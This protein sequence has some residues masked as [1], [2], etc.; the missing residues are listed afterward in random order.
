[1]IISIFLL[2]S[3]F[4]FSDLA[5][6]TFENKYSSLEII[7]K[8]KI[9][10]NDDSFIFGIKINLEDGWKTYWKNPGEAG[11]GMSLKWNKTSNISEMEVLYPF[12]KKYF[13][14]Q[15]ETIGYEKEIIFPIKIKP[16]ENVSSI[17]TEL[18]IEYLICKEICIPIT[19]KKIIRFSFNDFLLNAS[20]NEIFE[21]LNK[22][23]NRDSGLFKIKKIVSIAENKIKLSLEPADPQKEDYEVYPFSDDTMLSVSSINLG[24]EINIVLNLDEKLSNIKYPF[25]LSISDGENM[26]EITIYLDQIKIKSALFYY[27]LLAF[28][29]GL[30]LNFMPCVLPVLSLKLFSL[31][32]ISEKNSINVR[33]FSMAMIMGIVLSFVFLSLFII[34]FKAFGTELGWGFQF[35]NYKFLLFITF[36]ILIF[37]LNLLGFFEILLPNNLTN[38]INGLLGNQS[39]KSYFFSGVFSTL[40]ATPCSAPFLG[41]AVGFSIAS[42]YE[43]IF[44]IFILISIGFSFPYILFTIKPSLVKRLPKPGEWMVNFKFLLGLVLLLTFSWFLHILNIEKS[45]IAISIFTILLSSILINKSG[46]SI[47]SSSVLFILIIYT[48]FFPNLKNHNEVKWEKFDEKI[49]RQYIKEENLIFLDFTA[50]WCV[51]CQLNKVT[52]LDSKKIK[53]YFIDNDVKLLRGDWSQ[54]DEKILNFISKFKRYGIPVNIVYGPGGKEGILLPEILTKHIVIDELNL[55][56]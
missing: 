5:S 50:N 38:N 30:L 51:T 52:T 28:I 41:T 26:E 48:F 1:M 55:I 53:K 46:F 18:I 43:N 19:E 24:N 29:G 40:M 10:K 21:Y 36:I 20:E 6:Q 25:F 7:P 12:P 22:V 56:K 23:P 45:I 54:K 11:A 2:F 39:V 32:S 31:I 9:I 16:K 37:C 49:L 4:L 33:E 42:S 3:C 15:V 44:F 34:S 13:D 17:N 35:Q 14:H 27:L 47:I 8:S